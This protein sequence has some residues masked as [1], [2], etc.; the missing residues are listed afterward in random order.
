MPVSKKKKVCTSQEERAVAEFFSNGNI[1]LLAALYA[2][3]HVTRWKDNAQRVFATKLFNRKH[4]A[5]RVAQAQAKASRKT[6]LTAEYCLAT[7]KEN[8]DRSMQ[9]VPVTDAAGNILYS[10]GPDGKTHALF[11]YNGSVVNQ[12][13]KMVMEHIGIT[14]PD[15]RNRDSLSR[16]IEKIPIEKRVMLADKLKLIA[17]KK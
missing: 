2:Y 8:I 12:G 4:V 11:A 1:K 7:L 13:L 3:P 6:D 5:E 14:K 17:G 9:Y 16:S 15:G 10:Q